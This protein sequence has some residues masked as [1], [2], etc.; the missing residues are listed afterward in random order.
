VCTT[1][2]GL[3]FAEALINVVAGLFTLAIFVRAVLSWVPSLRLPL[4]L[5]PL[6]VGLTEPIQRPIR[7]VLP[8]TGGVDFSPLVALLA[9]QIVAALLLRVLP[10][11]V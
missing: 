6:V 4:G 3:L 9:V 10:P 11:A 7:R 2:L 1:C 8:G 5:G